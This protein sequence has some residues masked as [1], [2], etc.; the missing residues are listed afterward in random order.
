MLSQI[1]LKETMQY[2][3]DHPHPRLWKLLADSALEEMDLDTATKGF[4]RSVDYYGISVVKNLLKLDVRA[5]Y[6][7]YDQILISDIPSL[8]KRDEQRWLS[9]LVNLI[10][11]KACTWKWIAKIWP[12]KCGRSW[13]T[14]LAF[15]SS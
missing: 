13:V 8:M 9:T 12:S 15:C 5:E 2:I 7:S 3:E 14:G 11:R 1:G 10:V 4:V 6:A